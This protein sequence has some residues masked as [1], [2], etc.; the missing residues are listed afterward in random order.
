MSCSIPCG[1]NDTH[2]F[3]VCGCWQGH[4]YVYIAETLYLCI[5]ANCPEMS[6]IVPELEPMS[7]VPHRT[8]L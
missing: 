2:D 8:K 1:A 3:I 5:G 7:H 6:G 4:M